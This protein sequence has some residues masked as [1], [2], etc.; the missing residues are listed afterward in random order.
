MADVLAAVWAGTAHLMHGHIEWLSKQIFATTSER[1][2]LLEQAAMYGITPTPAT[3]ASGTVAA[4]G[5]DPTPIPIGTI[6]VRDDGVT[7]ISTVATLMSGSAA[8]VSI[9]AV[10]AGVDANLD[11]GETLAFESPIAGIDSTVTVDA[12]GLAGGNDEEST[13]GTRD[14]LLLRLQEPPTGGSDQDYEAWALAVAG[15]TRAWIFRHEDGLGTVTVRFVRDDDGSIFPDAGEVTTVQTALDAERPTTA[16]VTAAAPVDLPVAFTIAITPNDAATQAAVNAELEDMFFRVAEP[17]DG[18]GLG[19]VKLIDIQN[20]IFIAEGL[21]DYTLT[22][23]A[24][25]VVPI[26]GELATRGAMTWL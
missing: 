24:A 22:V 17:G 20:A 26:L 10:E 15:V 21:T 23:P 1:E 2:F 6:F 14:R 4:T 5:T 18:A 8:T 12:P 13:E 16:E 25:D 7:Y 11:A 9:D 3:F 19:T